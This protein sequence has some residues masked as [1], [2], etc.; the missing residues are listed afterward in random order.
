MSVK[1]TLTAARELVERGWHQGNNTDG[2]G[3]Y[4]LRAAVGLA[5]GAMRDYRG[6]VTFSYI[7]RGAPAALH[8]EYLQQV[9]TENK[10]INLVTKC[11]P[12]PFT[13]VP[14]YNDDPSTTKEDVLAVL[15]KA[16]SSC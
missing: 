7:S 2:H 16:I 5:S 12:E 14:I 13:S 4:C 8:A 10:A 1:D 3:N 6:L 11:L 15:D 9:V